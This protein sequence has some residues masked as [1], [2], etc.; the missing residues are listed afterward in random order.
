[1]LRPP[2]VWDRRG[3]PNVV[4]KNQ[5][6]GI[7]LIFPRARR[8]ACERPAPRNPGGRDAKIIELAKNLR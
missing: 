6:L 3:K 1:M 7:M 8:L 4:T 2:T 5:N